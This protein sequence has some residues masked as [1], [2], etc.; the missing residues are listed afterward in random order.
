MKPHLTTQ[1]ENKQ[2]NN[3]Q[4]RILIIILISLFIFSC[5]AQEYE[6]TFKVD[7][8]QEKVSKNIALRGNVSPL[9][10]EKDYQLIDANGDGIYEATIKFKT[11]KR[12]VRFKFSND[13]ELELY[14]SDNRIL[15]FK[16]ESFITN[17][18]FNEFNVYNEQKLE[19]LT[20]NEA[21]IK[22][23]IM[24]L[25]ETLEFI[26]PNLY[27]YRDSVQLNQ[28]FK[29]LETNMLAT[30][31]L[32]NAYKEVSKFAANIK[33]SH[34]FT[35]PWNQGPDVKMATFHQ[36]DKV[37]FTF[38]RIG[39]RLFL[40][41]NASSNKQLKKGLEILSIND[42]STK[43]IMTRL[44]NYITSDGNNYEKRLQRLTLSGASKFELF[45]IFFPL[46][47]P[48]NGTFQ[49]ELKNHTTGEI[50]KTSVKAM[51]KTKRTRILKERYVHF[52]SSFKEGWKFD[53]LDSKTAKLSIESF[54]IFSS[55]F[56]WKNF[57]DSS[58]RTL[59]N[60]KI[61]NLIIDIRG[62]EGGDAQVAEYILERIIKKSI[63]VKLPAQT[64]AYRK[65]P[66]NLK[67]Y[68]STWDK[69]PYDW[70]NK[71]KQLPDGNFKLKDAYAETSQ[72]YKPRKGGFRGNIYLL[73]NA[74]NSS[75]T[76]IMATYVKKY[77]LATIVGQETGGN[78][79]GLNGGYMFF[80]R[81]P[82]TRVELD[83]PVFSIKILEETSTTYDGGIKP[84]VLVE[85]NV[86]DLVNGV[87]TELNKIL[88]IIENK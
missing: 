5:D 2:T 25:R 76:H 68:I 19:K 16:K 4:M 57:L 87:D 42:V 77:N 80:H 30:P 50:Q 69:R 1:T 7:M 64:T 70:A 85:K 38:N 88:E 81:L 31:T 82:N 8:N 28:D 47:F 65:I 74:E 73:T 32:I 12:N 60:R 41:K 75:A 51:S 63:T 49:L 26:H 34:T 33:C 53:V 15:W 72:T 43:Q 66:E 36:A 17:Y 48:N 20:Y 21:K 11:S 27:K 23:D 62:N 18:V 59:N 55:D 37:P 35:N 56:K 61:E 83:I 79:K 58:F 3:K 9:S 13:K 54:A 14:G 40:D 29:N 39:K 46:E 71:V 45:D 44:V 10:W 22:E 67:K 84:D 52:D 24:V 6:V 78:Q 86:N